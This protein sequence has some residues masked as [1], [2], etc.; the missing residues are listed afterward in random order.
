MKAVSAGKAA[1][2]TDSY[3]NDQVQSLKK[4][5]EFLM[6]QAQENTSELNELRHYLSG[7]RSCDNAT[8]K[9]LAQNMS[10]QNE[11][12]QEDLAEMNKMV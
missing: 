3:L 12:L 7:G 2:N 8:L 5:N 1:N 6:Q 11:R 4:A 9:Q 10:I